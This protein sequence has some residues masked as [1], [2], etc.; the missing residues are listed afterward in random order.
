MI[1]KTSVA[2]AVAAGLFG[3][4]AA[5]APAFAGANDG[6]VELG[7]FVLWDNSSYSG[8]I[9]DLA[10]GQGTGLDNYAGNGNFINTSTSIDDHANSIA[11]YV[12]GYGLKAYTGSNLTGTA[13]TV[14]AFGLYNTNTSYAYVDL[15]ALDNTL[16][17]HKYD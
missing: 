12:Q 6:K 1:R 15:G 17:S 9:R 3:V 4:A 13:V 7:E 2:L 11:N 10:G 8:P 5:S 14:L 16:S